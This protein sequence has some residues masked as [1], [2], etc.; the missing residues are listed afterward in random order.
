MSR[1]GGGSRG[2][3]GGRVGGRRVEVEEGGE[4][5]CREKTDDAVVDSDGEWRVRS[6]GGQ[7]VTVGRGRRGSREGRERCER[8]G[9]GVG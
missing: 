6:V 5:D 1:W 8:K 4:G 2:G 3:G 9:G 7:R